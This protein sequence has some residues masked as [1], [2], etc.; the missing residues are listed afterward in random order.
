[1]CNRYRVYP[2]SLPCSLLSGLCS[3]VVTCTPYSLLSTLY[4]ILLCLSRINGQSQRHTHR[5]LI[6]AAGGISHNDP[7]S[8]GYGYGAIEILYILLC[9]PANTATLY[10]ES[11]AHSLLSVLLTTD[12]LLLF[13]SC[14]EICLSSS[15]CISIYIYA[16]PTRSRVYIRANSA[17]AIY[18]NRPNAHRID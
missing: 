15:V 5:F 7:N 6:S 4:S 16:D 17:V 8:T 13:L 14:F 10:T 9:S 2:L 1:M 11:T 18:V 12:V 3:V